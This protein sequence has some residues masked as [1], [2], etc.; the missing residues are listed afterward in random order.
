MSDGIKQEESDEVTGNREEH[1]VAGKE[2]PMWIK[3]MAE[4]L[5]DETS[6]NCLLTGDLHDLE[7]Q[8]EGMKLI[9]LY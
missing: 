1:K 3:R 6:Q 9:F 7:F 5:K 8:I 2:I 4:G